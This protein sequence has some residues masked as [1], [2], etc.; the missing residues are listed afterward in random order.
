[1]YANLCRERAIKYIPSHVGVKSNRNSPADKTSYYQGK[2]APVSISSPRLIEKYVFFSFSLQFVVVNVPPRAPSE[3][4]S[5]SSYP[6]GPSPR[7]PQ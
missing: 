6:R 7:S 2:T 1:M 4:H 5:S 3:F